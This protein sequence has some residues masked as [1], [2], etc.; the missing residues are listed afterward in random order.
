MQVII[1]PM[2]QDTNVGTIVAGLEK[3]LQE[4][5]VS[6]LAGSARQVLMASLQQMSDRPVCV[7]THNMYQAQKVYEDLIELVP[8]DQVLLY[9]G[10]ELIGSELAIASPEML[11]QRIHV[12]N[13]LAQGFTGFLVAP[14][15]GLRRLVVPPQVWKE[16]Q[17][18]LSVGDELDIDSFLLRCIELGYERV[19]MVERKGEMS[20]RGGIIDL[21]P[22]DSEWP[23]RI[24][25]F[26][27]E[28]DSI[29][30]FDM[31]SQRS[32]E[33]V[34]T[35]ILGP[36]KEM[37][38][39]TPLLQESAVRLEQK[40]GET[41]ANLKDGAAKEKVMERIG[42]DAERMKQGQ[43]FAQLYSYISVIYPTGDTLL[44]Y[45]PSDTLLIVDEPS[46]VLDTAAQ[47]QKEEGEWLTGRIIQGEYMSN[48]SL[49]RTYD[50]IVSTKKRQI[51]YLSLFLR[52]S[53]KTQPQN[54]V[55]LTCRTMQ[56]F[57]GQMNV[58]KTELARWKKS[59][60]QIV[61]VAADLERAKRLER[62]LHDYEMEADVLTDA[63]ETVPPGRPTIILGN[64]QTGFE[65]PL[66]KLVVITEGEVFTAKQRKARK[67][68]QTMNNA[69]RIKNYLE[70]K[71]GDFVV[72]VNHGIGKYLG[73]ETKE[74]LGIHKDYLHIQYAAG[75]SL[76]VPIDQIDHVQKYVASEE[77]QP[78]IYS[79]GGS[80]WKRVKNK[81]QSSVKDIAEDL[82]KLY[83]AREAAVG[84]TF[85]P[86]TTEQREFEAMFPYQETQD[87]LRAISEVKADME[88]KRPMDRLV[89]GDVGYGKTEVAIR[90]AFKSVMDGKQVAVLVPTTI[91]AQQHYETFRE[92]FAEYPIRVEVLS[93][94][95][96]RKEQ[97]A[98]LKGLKE[99]TVDVVIGTHRLLSKDLT[100]RE[101]GLLIVD[102]EQRFGVSH[103]EKLKQIKTN[104]D[105]MTLTATPIP[106]TLHMS[107]L[108]VRDLSVIETPP[109]NRFPVQTYVM[110]YSPALVREAIEREMARDGQVF[111]LYNQVQGIEQMAEQISMLV[112]DARIAVAHGQM[113]ESELEGVILDFLEGN[114]DV[115][116]STTII[117]TG[118]DIP[119][120]NTLIIYNADKM[121][122]S[123]LYQLR[124]RVGRSNRIAYAYFTYQRDKVLTE[125]AEK[126][127]QAI[128]EFTELGSGFKIA[129]RDLSIRGAGNLLGAEQHGFINTVGFDLY[130]QMLKE[131]I[132]EL[133][134]EVKHE[135]V[136]PVEIN[137]QLDAYIPSM[138]ITDS[139]QKI[140]M[141]KKFVAVS[142]LEDVDDLAEELLDR[143]G[144]VPKPVDNLLTIS[145]LRVYALKHH[146]TEISQKNPDEIKLFLHPS[147]NNNIDG[148]ALFA[149]TSNWSKRVGLSG[150]Q[151]ITIAVKVKGL[152]EDEGVQL[153]EKLLRQFHQVRRDTGT[154]SPVS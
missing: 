49:S 35:Y 36:A 143:F 97:N 114:F 84:H 43:R 127:L 100:F 80:E 1:N 40:L 48:L 92:R 112:P 68:Q 25:L 2:K 110:D 122:L 153:V 150:G 106:R 81:V 128:K 42:S 69:E 104:V 141:Y 64:L 8:S 73:I 125:V 98:T 45:M 28:I 17:I 9:P 107:M 105:V 44:S 108:G 96:S 7:V 53:P 154:E 34:Q 11:A 99:G 94:F 56:N 79:L 72:H 26:D 126:R 121:G 93:R 19:D 38:A 65:L 52:Q 77:A 37:I 32:L 151:Q 87:Q 12:F 21:Y 139:R 124:G 63:V 39:S 134:G 58:L 144:P 137:L 20:I 75:D 103:K 116:V 85:S 88:R 120:V 23:V 15:A 95:R 5:L 13:R 133:K 115:L 22:I 41:I 18:Q 131:A 10:N 118:V 135:I 27:V 16:A 119:N 14:F 74:I 117:E 30:T 101:L 55:N 67:V 147:Q 71:P 66:N 54:I 148:G 31:L 129:M 142:T 4:Q 24:E 76:F 50:E 136:T 152:K 57:H 70:L 140:E 130:S 132:D 109:E 46:R 78:K 89:C 29:R 102:E 90:A 82:I 60:D 47:L 59:Q 111:F 51:V 123:Q 3:G 33:S 6:G 113:N 91:L 145:R 62:V 138:Y 149:L 86:D 83:A 146:I 61:F